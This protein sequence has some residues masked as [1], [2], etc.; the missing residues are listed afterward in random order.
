[1]RLAILT[2][3][4][5]CPGLNAIIRAAV[6]CGISRYGHTFAGY[7]DGW[8]GVVDDEWIELDLA[9]VRGSSRGAGRSSG[10]PASTR[11]SRKTVPTASGRRSRATDA[12]A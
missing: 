6:R 11:C 10:A 2:G 9:A 4:G 1:M 3:G 8:G 12:T 7:I 5:D